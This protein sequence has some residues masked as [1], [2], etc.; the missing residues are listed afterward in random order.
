MTE[1]FS[2]VHGLLQHDHAEWYSGDPADEAEDAEDTEEGEHDRG[3][4]VLAIKVV[5]ACSDSER[6]V[7]NA[8]DPDELLREC[9]CRGEIRPG[10]DKGYQ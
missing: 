2:D 3:G 9:S 6:D 10:K 4:V 7:Q 1:A 5:D 8:G